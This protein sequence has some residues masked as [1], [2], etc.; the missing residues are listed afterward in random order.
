M[1]ESGG[2]V[3]IKLDLFVFTFKITTKS[4]H[5]VFLGWSLVFLFHYCFGCSVL[6]LNSHVQLFR[7]DFCY[8]DT[9]IY[10]SY[11]AKT[12]VDRFYNFILILYLLYYIIIFLISRYIKTL[13]ELSQN[14]KYF[15]EYN[16]EEN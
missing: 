8:L 7:Y 1:L 4:L 13:N 2:K 9:F 14:I 6:F 5:C 11:T 15:Y 12:Y 3:K 10:Q 16:H